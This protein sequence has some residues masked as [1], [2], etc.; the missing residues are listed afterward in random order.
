M[1]HDVFSDLLIKEVKKEYPELKFKK[2]P[3]IKPREELMREAQQ[4]K[5]LLDEMP[6]MPLKEGE[7]YH[8][9]AMDWWV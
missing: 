5:K 7:V 1:T 8:I 3:V 6:P 2:K 4:V 9:V